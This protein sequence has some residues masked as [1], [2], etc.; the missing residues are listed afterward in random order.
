LRGAEKESWSY[1]FLTPVRKA[2]VLTSCLESREPQ[3]FIKTKCKQSGPYL[4]TNSTVGTPTS[5]LSVSLCLLAPRF[6]S[7]WSVLL[8]SPPPPQPTLPK[9]LFMI[10][11]K[12]TVAV[13][14]YTRRGH[15]IPLQMVVSH[16]V[17]AGNGT[18]DI[19][20]SSQCS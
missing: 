4:G 9:H 10:I 14:R 18:Q 5:L 6:I 17:V 12:Y 20:K 15:Q 16:H 2:G 3:F 1:F 7:V 13:F 8:S 11:C 19:W